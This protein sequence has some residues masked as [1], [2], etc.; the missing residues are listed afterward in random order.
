MHVN[1]QATCSHMGRITF[2]TSNVR[3]L[4]NGQAAL[5]ASDVFTVAACPFT[6]PEP[7]P[8][9]CVTGNW[10]QPATRVF[11]N[12]QPAVLNTSTGLCNA[13]PQIPQ[14]PPLVTG[15][16]TRVGGS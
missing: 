5:V 7:K 9:P 3:V 2:T 10:L 8:S 1:A 4:V 12:G 13:A 15:V 6:T 14:G 16:Q 11:I